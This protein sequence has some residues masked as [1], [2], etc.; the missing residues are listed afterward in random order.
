M[1]DFILLHAACVIGAYYGAD[2]PFFA[3]ALSDGTIARMRATF[4]DGLLRWGV[5][6]DS[7]QINMSYPA[8]GIAPITLSTSTS[9]ACCLRGGTVYLL[10]ESNH[11]DPIIVILGP[12]DP[13]GESSIN[14]LQGFAAGN[15]CVDGIPGV[16]IA[17][18][19]AVLIFASGGI[20]KV[21]T[22]ALLAQL[23]EDWVLQELIDNGTI[24]LLRDLLCSF[25]EDDKLL[26]SEL[27][28]KAR[29]ELVQSS[30][31]DLNVELLNLLSF[32]NTRQLLLE[33]ATEDGSN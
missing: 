10:P 9:V 22:C 25:N 29:E 32:I 6:H 28:R 21:C 13:D 3:A 4:E 31:D 23:E 12:I 2:R 24:T 7:D 16:P 30:N 26:E 27:W 18:Q 20:M 11:L 8:I 1:T 14:Y 33:L 5:D 17:N 15:L 19:Q